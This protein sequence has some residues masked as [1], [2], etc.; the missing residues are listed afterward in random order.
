MNGGALSPTRPAV[1]DLFRSD[2]FLELVQDLFET[3]AGGFLARWILFER[4]QKIGDIALCR[5]Q[6]I[7]V[8]DVPVP[9]GIGG[10]ICTFVG[11]QA[12]VEQLGAPQKRIRLEPDLQRAPLPLLHEHELPVVVTQ[13]G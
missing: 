10:N 13:S 7:S 8:V 12:Q 4:G 5:H 6:Q 1:S 11:V 2:I 3:E 9:L